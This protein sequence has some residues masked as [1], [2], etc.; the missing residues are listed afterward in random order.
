MISASAESECADL[1]PFE[2]EAFPP[3]HARR[4]VLAIV[5]MLTYQGFVMS[6]NGVGSPWIAKSFALT[7][8]QIAAL[9][10]WISISALGTLV[11][12]RVAD[13]VG[14]RRVLLWCMVATPLSALSAALSTRLALFAVCEICLYTFISATVAASIVMLAEAL[15][16]AARARGQSYGGLATGLGG[17][18]CVILMPLLARAGY[19]WRWL[20]VL[21]AAGLF[22]LPFV[23]H[24]IPESRRWERA[25]A[26]G[27]TRRKFSDVFEARY[28]RRAI[29]VMACSLLGMIA[30]TAAGSWSYFHAVSVVGLPAGVAST[31]ILVGGSAG[32][33]GFPFGA[34]CCERF[35]RVPTV[36]IAGFWAGLGALAFYWGPPLHFTHPA[37]W[38]GAGFAWFTGAANASSVAGNAAATELFPTAL[39]GT[40][41]GW[42]TLI[43]AIGAVVAH[44]AIALLTVPLGG[45]STVVGYLAL[46]SM[47]SAI[48]F[49]LFIEETRGLSLEVA[50]REIV[51]ET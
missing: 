29:P 45:L 10:A 28:R 25:A 11:L 47:P 13:R 43:A 4:T 6:I 48:I 40:M 32:I 5:A 39:R 12:S 27:V 38:L 24:S 3:G 26:S 16:I 33:L 50:A 31:L 7:D 51:S 18:I 36:V 8:S 42:F 9:F 30:G 23:A 49:G 19:S 35:G 2:E 14:R 17:G 44:A 46:L 1:A 34:W 15:P 41:M 22:A 20:L 37:V 21:A